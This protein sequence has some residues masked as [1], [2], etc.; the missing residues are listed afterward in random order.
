MAKK[1]VLRMHVSV[2]NKLA[3]N[4]HQKLKEV[5]NL[6]NPYADVFMMGANRFG[7]VTEAVKVRSDDGCEVMAE[8]ETSDLTTAYLA[9]VRKRLT[10]C[11]FIKTAPESGD[12]H[13]YGSESPIILL[14]QMNKD[15]FLA[16]FG[17]DVN[18]VRAYRYVRRIDK[19]DGC[20][21]C[22]EEADDCSN[23]WDSIR[24]EYKVVASKS[25]RIARWKQSALKVA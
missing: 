3:R 24:V 11:G 8:L 1:T 6:D 23:N 12:N 25:R 9:I 16:L 4:N 19:C 17:G 10:P 13:G 21:K 15:S 18:E 5:E 2:H 14:R 22:H 7:V 20:D